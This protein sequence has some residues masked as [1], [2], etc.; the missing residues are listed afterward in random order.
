MTQ[1][2]SV[3][4]RADGYWVASIRIGCKKVVRYA[5]SERD[6]ARKLHDLL[7][8]HHLG[9][10]V[11]PN[12]LTLE[13]WV[14]QWLLERKLRPSTLRTYVEVLAPVLHQIGHSRLDKLTPLLL[15]T[16]LV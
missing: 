15:S 7:K 13:E 14:Q 1:Q 9:A 12:R 6:A 5:K 10:L 2:G 11:Q 16:Y 4:Q 3:Y 8:E